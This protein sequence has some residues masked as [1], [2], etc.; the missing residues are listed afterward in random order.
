MHNNILVKEQ[1]K[2]IINSSTA[3]HIYIKLKVKVTHTC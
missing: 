3:V 2:F 1:Y